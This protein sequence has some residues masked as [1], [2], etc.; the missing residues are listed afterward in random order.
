MSFVVVLPQ[1]RSITEAD[2]NH[3][4]SSR[5]H[6]KFKAFK[7]A[8]RA[9]MWFLERVATKKAIQLYFTRAR[10]ILVPSNTIDIS[11]DMHGAPSYTINKGRFSA[12][13]KNTSISLAHVKNIA[14]GGIAHKKM[15]GSLGVHVERVRNFKSA[16]LK[17]FLDS[18]EMKEV[19]HYKTAIKK[20]EN[21]TILWSIKEA[22]IKSKNENINPKEIVVKK[23]RQGVYEIYERC[24]LG[25]LAGFARSWFP[26]VGYV[27]T[28]VYMK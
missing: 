6:K 19:T 25:T 21:A 4:L 1:K 8:P 14:I 12:D 22:Y 17:A 5:E 27:A 16:F 24:S 18:R 3:F 20:K 15:E 11:E 28:E 2:A 9:Y 26:Q 13:E 23:I 10:G 7:N